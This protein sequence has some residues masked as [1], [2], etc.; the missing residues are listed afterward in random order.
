[1]SFLLVNNLNISLLCPYA[2]KS[3]LTLIGSLK[4]FLK[5]TTEL[6]SLFNPILTVAAANLVGGSPFPKAK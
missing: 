4:G 1:M 5:C 2:S 6:K 3:I